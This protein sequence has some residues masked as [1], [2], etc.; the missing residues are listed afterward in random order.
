MTL[1]TRVGRLSDVMGHNATPHRRTRVIIVEPDETEAES[2]L[3]HFGEPLTPEAEEQYFIMAIMIV[4]P[5]INGGPV[6][7]ED[8]SVR[9]RPRGQGGALDNPN[10]ERAVYVMRD[11]AGGP[12][13]AS[14]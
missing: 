8:R 7:P 5:G 12:A 10:R 9:C 3:R 4:E 2:Y 14:T 1:K 13:H 11:S 6:D